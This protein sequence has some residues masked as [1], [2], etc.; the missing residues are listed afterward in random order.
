MREV[1]YS[2]H[3]VYYDQKSDVLYFGVKRGAEEE[4]AEV[5]PGVSVELDKFGNAIGVEVLNASQVL[6]PVAK[7]LRL[8]A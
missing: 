8:A 6:K 5:A 1:V 4:F 3:N 2:K 7:S